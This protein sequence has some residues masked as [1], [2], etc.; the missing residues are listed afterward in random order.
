MQVCLCDRVLNATTGLFGTNKVMSSQKKSTSND[1]VSTNS[2]NTT[3]SNT[4]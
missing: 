2:T 1:I 4:R 3:N